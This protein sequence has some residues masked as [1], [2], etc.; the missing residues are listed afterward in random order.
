[1]NGNVM[2][3]TRH[4]R[5]RH[6]CEY[7]AGDNALRDGSEQRLEHE[8]GDGA[9]A[10]VGHRPRTVADR[11]LRLDREEQGARE[12]GDAVDA[13]PV[14]VPLLHRPPQ[15][16]EQHPAQHERHQVD[17]HVVPAQSQVRC[18]LS[19]GGVAQRLRRCMVGA[20]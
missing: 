4:T 16:R 8:E 11:V 12:A 7:D 1:M 13:R 18:S 6:L 20:T 17:Q 19:V 14:A 3:E 9:R 15:Q 2:L 5:R 10:A